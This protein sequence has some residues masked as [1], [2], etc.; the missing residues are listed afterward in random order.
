MQEGGYDI[1]H[2]QIYMEANPDK[3]EMEDSRIDD[4]RERHWRMFLGKL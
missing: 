3:K 4:E 2:E 1:K